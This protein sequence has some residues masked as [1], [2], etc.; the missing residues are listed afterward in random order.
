MSTLDFY[1]SNLKVLLYFEKKNMTK[2][3]ILSNIDAATIIHLAW[4]DKAGSL[5]HTDNPITHN[6][7]PLESTSCSFGKWFFGAGQVLTCIMSET[8]IKEVEE[9]HQELHDSYLQIF[10]IYFTE[11][12]DKALQHFSH[13]NIDQKDQD[14][15][16]VE[17]RNLEN[18]SEKLI[19]LLERIKTNFELIDNEDLKGICH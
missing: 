13:T 4:V 9:T 2:N 17:L 16:E 11:T 19:E 18:I 3:E 6:E 1:G 5:V 7:I 12:T 15:A 10:K 14:R 8:L